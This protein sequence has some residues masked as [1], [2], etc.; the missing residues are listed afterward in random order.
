MT[1]AKN[2]AAAVSAFGGATKGKLSNKAATGAPEDQLRTPVNDLSP[3]NAPGA[4]R[5]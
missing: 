1:E 3:K 4:R 5:S 2:L